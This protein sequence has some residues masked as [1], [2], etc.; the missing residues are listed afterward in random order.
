MF[1]RIERFK[2]I[3]DLVDAVPCVHEFEFDESRDRLIVFY[4]EDPLVSG[5]F[6]LLIHV[7]YLRYRIR[8]ASI[9]FVRE[10]PRRSGRR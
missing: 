8:P 5:T 4:D 2:P 10:A 1:D 3:I 7:D 9:P 6:S